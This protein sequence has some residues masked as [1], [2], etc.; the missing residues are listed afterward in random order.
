MAQQVE[1]TLSPA[2]NQKKNV[3]AKFLKLGFIQVIRESEGKK[4]GMLPEIQMILKP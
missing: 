1:A 2:K 3:V 4:K